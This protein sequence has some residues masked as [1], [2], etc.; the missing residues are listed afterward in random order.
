MRSGIKKIFLYS[1]IG[2][3]F[4]T[5]NASTAE[6]LKL[7]F[8]QASPACTL[9]Q[10]VG[11][12]N[13]TVDYSRPGAKGRK[14]FGDVVPFDQ[15]WR[16]GANGATK[17]SFSTPVRL[18]GHKVDAGNYLLLTIPGESEWTIILNKAAELWGTAKYDKS[19]DAVR[20]TVKP[21][22]IIEL[23]DAFTIEFD[24][25]RDQSSKLNLIWDKTKIP[26]ELKVEYV[27]ELHKQIEE[28]MKSDQKDKPFFRAAA[29][30]YEHDLDLE[31]AKLW[32]DAALK[33]S[34]AF[35]MVHMKALILEKLGEKEAAL[36]EAKRSL[37]LSKD[38]DD[39]AYIRKNEALIKS[40]Q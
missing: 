20:F 37:K 32:I 7:E 36:A 24:T 29:F 27:N 11:L 12:T 26:I 3:V 34:E 28:V 1:I 13:I 15:I 14:I 9:K 21:N 19:L 4:M 25:I 30:Y 17:I 2:G 22:T 6:E 18:N 40:I 8:P 10:R 38:A 33:E 5:S 35:Y 23:R 16:T 31:K 39:Y